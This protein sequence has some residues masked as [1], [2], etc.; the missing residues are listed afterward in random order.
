VET[1]PVI[2]FF[3]QQFIPV[4]LEDLYPKHFLKHICRSIYGVATPECALQLLS[5]ENTFAFLYVENILLNPDGW[6]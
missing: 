5:F 2:I 3:S 6:F 4:M 1:F